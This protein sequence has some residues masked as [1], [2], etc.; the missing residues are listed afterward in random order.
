MDA[1]PKARQQINFT[2]IVDQ[3]FITQTFFI[4]REAKETVLDF[5]KRTV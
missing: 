2:G 3:G 4:I 1:D 5:S